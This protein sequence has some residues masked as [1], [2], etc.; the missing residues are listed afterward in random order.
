MK[1]GQLVSFEKK[2][3]MAMSPGGA[4][5]ENRAKQQT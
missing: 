1:Q 5:E 3:N 4:G 2:R